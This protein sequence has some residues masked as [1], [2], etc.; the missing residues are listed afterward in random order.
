M[1]I[2]SVS[3]V[4]PNPAGFAVMAIVSQNNKIVTVSNDPKFLCFNGLRRECGCGILW[5]VD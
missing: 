5:V 3:N 1:K 4:A 2:E